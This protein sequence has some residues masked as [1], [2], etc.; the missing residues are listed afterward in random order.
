M[1]IPEPRFYLK[2]AQAKEPT[3]ICMQAK[4]NGQRV[5]MSTGDK[6]HPD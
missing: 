4:Y 6:I 3:L 5:F 1:T 2:V